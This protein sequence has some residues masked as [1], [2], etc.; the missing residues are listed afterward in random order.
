MHNSPMRTAV[1]LLLAFVCT[2]AVARAQC[3]NDQRSKDQRAKEESA[4][5]NGG[6]LVTDFTITGTQTLS[7]TELAQITGEITESCFNDDSDEMGERVRALFQDRGYFK[8]EVKSLTLKPTDPLGSPKPVTMEADVA[9]GLQ[10]RVDQITFL[11]N[12]AFSS[13]RLREAFPLRKGDVFA[14]QKIASGL[15]DIRKLY[16]TQGYLD[17]VCIPDTSF[18]AAAT[19]KVSVIEGTQYHMGKL[20]I[21]AEKQLADR[22]RL[23]WKLDEG[24]VFDST[25]IDKYIQE[26]HN[27]LPDGFGR[28]RV[29]LAKDCPEAI[30]AVRLAVEDKEA[31]APMKDV[32]CEKTQDKA[33][34]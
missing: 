17:M 20:E 3:A 27:L 8:V 34:Q 23:A 12:H 24:K 21:L 9:E 15:D 6:I 5:K 25:Y 33:K 1:R 31:T 26:N 28:D 30:V 29:Q 19:L 2:A 7:A 22:L 18:A 4:N 10:F 14:R 16:A 13:A 32:P 11:E